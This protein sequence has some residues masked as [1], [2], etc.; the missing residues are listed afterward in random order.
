LDILRESDSIRLNWWYRH[1]V[2]YGSLSS[3]WISVKSAWFIRI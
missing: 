1:G 3:E 2:Q